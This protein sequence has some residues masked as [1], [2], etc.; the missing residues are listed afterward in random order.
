MKRLFVI[1]VLLV[2][3]AGC[4]GG[5]VIVTPTPAPEPTPTQETWGGACLS[6]GVVPIHP[7][8][9]PENPQH[10]DIELIAIPAPERWDYPMTI[11][12]LDGSYWVSLSNGAGF[13]G[14]RIHGLELESGR[15]YVVQLIG[16]SDLIGT[17]YFS[18][19]ENYAVSVNVHKSNG[20]TVALHS[21]SFKRTIDG[22]D[23][24]TADQDWF[25]GLYSND[26]YPTV[27]VDV[28]V[29]GLYPVAQPGNHLRIDA[30][31]VYRTSDNGHCA[32]VPGV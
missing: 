18:G 11:D 24:L 15:C 28:G 16:A 9:C 13:T 23:T 14:V 32:G 29:I 4:E 21:Q 22:K 8:A 6:T 12:Y 26:P 25:W 2:L 5:F 20:E 3:L 1:V 27:V 19:L 31:Y 30:A 7:G 17:P 10:A